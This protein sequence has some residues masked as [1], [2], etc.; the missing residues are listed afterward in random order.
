MTRTRY[1]PAPVPP[2]A[3]QGRPATG[4]K[5]PR[6]R[7]THLATG[8]PGCG[9]EAGGSL[10]VAVLVS[11]V[12]REHPPPTAS[13]CC[14]LGGQFAPLCPLPKGSLSPCSMSPGPR[15]RPAQRPSSGGAAVKCW[16]GCMEGLE[17][18]QG[19]L[20]RGCALKTRL[21][22]GACPQP[23]PRA[24]AE[25]VAR[26]RHE[27]SP[28][29]QPRLAPGRGASCSEEGHRNLLLGPETQGCWQL[30]SGNPAVAPDV[31]SWAM[32]PVER[33]ACTPPSRQ[34]NPWGGGRSCLNSGHFSCT[35]APCPLAPVCDL[36]QPTVFIIYISSS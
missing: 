2:A 8:L 20:P 13:P 16:G 7:G 6:W 9:G 36:S 29:S 11:G 17:D 1:P 25:R 33:G 19:P 14:V 21:G 32:P 24:G 35:T 4:E 5:C 31:R 10:G 23:S 3:Q 15:V 12:G 22:N 27:T 28:R 26:S 30:P 34:L 18:L